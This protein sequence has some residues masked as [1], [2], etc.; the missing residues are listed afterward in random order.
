MSNKIKRRSGY[1]SIPNAMAS[2]TR[3]SIEARGLLA[4]LMTMGE[5]WVFRSASLIKQ[6]GC[7]REKY[8]R[9]IREIKDA[10]YL[11]IEPDRND[12]GTLSHNWTILDGP[13][14][15]GKPASVNPPCGK[16]APIRD[17]NNIRDNNIRKRDTKVSPKKGTRLPPDWVLC[18]EWGEWAIDEGFDATEIRR[19]AET[20]RDYWISVP[21]Q[22]GVK[23]DWQATWRNW[24][25]RN[26]KKGNY[27]NG[28]AT[29]SQQRLDAFIAGARGSN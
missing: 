18:R 4:L 19:E 10:G 22:K 28:K 7:G 9:M 26:A 5:G 11:T 1:S 24:M 29:R 27:I 2:D 23:L 3:M 6:C 17:N 8:Q 21:G 13:P 12:D 15:A 25:R 16:P 20:F 14:R